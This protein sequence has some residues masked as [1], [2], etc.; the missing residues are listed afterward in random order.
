MKLNNSFINFSYVTVGRLVAVTL[1]AVFYLLF[2]ALLEPEIY[3]ELNYLIAL[4]GTTALISR[5]GLNFTITIYRAKNNTKISN[6]INTLALVSISLAAVFLL[7]INVFAAFLSLAISFFLMYQG[8]LLG[9]KKYKNFMF[10]AFLRSSSIIIFPILLYFIFDIPGILLG[11]A[12][13]NIIACIPFFKKI[14]LTSFFQLKNNY[15][16]LIHNFGV[17]ASTELSLTVDKLLVA[18]LFGFFIVGV[19]Q[20]NIQ[21]LIGLSVLPTI[22]YSFLLSEES[23]GASHKK[24]TYLAFIVSI[25]MAILAYVLAPIFVNEFF[26]KYSEG[27]FGLQIMIWSIIPLTISSYFNAKLQARESTKI[28]YSAIFRIGLLL[29]LLAWLGQLYGF[30]GLSLAILFSIISNTIFLAI[31]YYKSKP[32]PP[33]FNQEEDVLK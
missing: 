5:F 31:L 25:I 2:A 8:N 9:L 26:P 33:S 28:G 24:I 18:P 21:I 23:S 20:L 15:K 11:M 30:V 1:Q 14:K 10:N 6:Q 22:L 27:I 13:G 3:G 17:N 16:V 29:L 7:F 32:K 19:Y 4:A 12:I